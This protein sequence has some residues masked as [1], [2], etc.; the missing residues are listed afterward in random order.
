MSVAAGALLAAIAA[1]SS[2]G[3][4]DPDETPVAGGN[5]YVGS[6]S[7]MAVDSN[8]ASYTAVLPEIGAETDSYL[9]MGIESVGYVVPS[10]YDGHVFM[11]GGATPELTKYTVDERGR[12]NE[13][14]RIS[15]A[16]SG[17]TRVDKAPVIGVDMVAPDK[18]YFYNRNSYEIM[19]WNP[20]SMELTGKVINLEAALTAGISE[21]WI[22]NVFLNYGDGFAV[23]RGNRLFIPVSWRNWDVPDV[24]LPTAGLIVIDTDNDTFVHLLR[25]ERLA[26][27]IY[28]VKAASGDIYLFTGG[29]G[30]A[31]HRVLGNAAP[32]GA[33][34]LLD[35][36]DTFDPSYYLNLDSVL[37][38]RPASTPV[39]ADGSNVYVR[40]YHEDRQPITPEIEAD[41]TLLSTQEAWR[42]WKV[43]LDGVHAI[44]EITEL[45]WSSSSGYFYQIPE[46]N[47]FFLSVMSADFASTQ[48]YESTDDGFLKVADVTGSLD[49]LARLY[50]QR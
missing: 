6:L 44:R 40:A 24:F 11:P 18:A 13:V 28:T 46:E 25:D 29:F 48:L 8:P 36:S 21:G 5:L 37:G 26:D 3:D 43:D 39:L 22:P 31:Y 30:V 1:C 27:S 19:I 16:A 42:H 14:G 33:L 10:T 34:R 47:R 20:S 38:D 50:R 49:M 35:G 7:V 4:R 15:L 17:V 23:Q 45:P 32:G 9:R 12:F 2:D 41:P